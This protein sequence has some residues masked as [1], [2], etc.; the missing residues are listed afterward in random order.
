M[1]SLKSRAT[2]HL[3]PVVTESDL[4]DVPLKRLCSETPTL[5]VTSRVGNVRRHQ[6]PASATRLLRIFEP[7]EHHGVDYSLV[8]RLVVGIP[9]QACQLRSNHNRYR[10]AL[11]SAA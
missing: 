3:G 11:A 9:E 7:H 1:R 6:L 8:A 4:C 2:A 5:A 10:S